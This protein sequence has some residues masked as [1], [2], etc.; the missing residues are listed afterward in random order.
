MH[1]NYSHCKN[2]LKNRYK[3]YVIHRISSENTI[4]YGKSE[5]KLAY[6][7]SYKI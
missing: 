1:R 5:K 4:E 3:L 2:H 7:K 6:D